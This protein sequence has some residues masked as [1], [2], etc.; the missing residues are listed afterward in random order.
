MKCRRYRDIQCLTHLLDFFYLKFN[1]NVLQHN[2]RKLKFSEL[3]SLLFTQM[4]YEEVNC[5]K[6]CEFRGYFV[7]LSLLN[8]RL[9]GSLVNKITKVQPK[10]N[11]I[12]ICCDKM[13]KNR[14]AQSDF[15]STDKL[16][17]G[18]FLFN[19]RNQSII[20]NGMWVV[21]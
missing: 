11:F 18:K 21:G 6:T 9:P 19:C 12:S 14:N 1:C 17:S 3:I 13:N 4:V 2:G 15:L 16:L 8:N 7:A 20:I 5:I 10:G